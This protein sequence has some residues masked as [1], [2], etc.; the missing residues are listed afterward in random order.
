M[1]PLAVQQEVGNIAEAVC[2]PVSPI[3]FLSSLGPTASILK[4]R[5]TSCEGGGVR[6][7][8]SSTSRNLA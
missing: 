7:L 3:Y 8:D 2:D 5:N 4:V 6:Y 1:N